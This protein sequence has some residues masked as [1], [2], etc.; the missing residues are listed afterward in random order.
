MA[1]ISDSVVDDGSLTSAW[2]I[3]DMALL[4]NEVYTLVSTWILANRDLNNSPRW[5]ERE[6]VQRQK[7]S[8]AG[9]SGWALAQ[10]RRQSCVA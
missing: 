9:M 6:L 10:T 4:M 7:P 3:A 8:Q 1:T 2:S 5:Y